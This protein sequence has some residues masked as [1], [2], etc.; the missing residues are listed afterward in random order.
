MRSQV[1]P[2]R[3]YGSPKTKSS[4]LLAL[5]QAIHMDL[6]QQGA[7]ETHYTAVQRKGCRLLAPFQ[8]EDR[9]PGR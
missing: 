2:E 3:R 4:L 6:S 8:V 1:T 7:V 5:G 9:S